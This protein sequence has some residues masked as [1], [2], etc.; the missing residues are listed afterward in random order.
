MMPAT[1]STSRVSARFDVIQQAD[2]PTRFVLVEVYRSEEDTVKHRQTAHFAAGAIRSMGCWLPRAHVS[3]TKMSIPMTR[4]GDNAAG[5]RF[6]HSSIKAVVLTPGGEIAASANRE[7]DSLYP[8]P[9]WVEQS[10]YAW[11]DKVV[12][13]IR[14][15][16]QEKPALAAQVSAVGFSGQMH[17]AVLLDAN[18]QPLRPA[19]IWADGRSQP[20]VDRVLE[21]FGP[22]YS[23]LTGNPLFTGF[24]LPTILWVRENEPEIWKRCRKVLLPKDYLRFLFTGQFLSEASDAS[25]TGMF[26]IARRVW[27]DCI[28]DGLDLEPGLLPDLIASTDIAGT[29]LP[30][31]ADQLGLPPGIPVICGGSDQACQAL[32][33]GIIN[34]GEVSCTIGTGGQVFAPLGSPL[35]DPYQ[36]LH[37]FCHILPDLWHIEA[38]TLSA[39]LSLRWLR[40]ILG[41]LS[42]AEMADLADQAPV[43]CDGLLFAPYLQGERTP[44]MDAQL[45]GGIVGLSIHH[46][47]QDLVRA[48][49]EGVV[50]SLRTGMELMT[51]ENPSPI[52]CGRIRRRR[53]ASTM[54]QADGRHLQYSGCDSWLSRSRFGRGSHAGGHWYRCVFKP[55]RGSPACGQIL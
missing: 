39:G 41:G 7:Y 49:M 25:S 5:D 2:D 6:G 46:T 9:G 35:A 8:K 45:R 51:G 28:L 27:S 43:G 33:N 47:R 1:A 40:G 23:R 14:Q 17:G 48:V 29:L 12:Q 10:P 38:A 44:Y 31:M 37:L 53:Q 50:L 55:S 19:V 30:E 42:Y 52:A 32:G 3:S 20:Q 26:D 24:M 36:R 4:T 22:E 34:P 54:A 21:Q 15:L 18:A 13:V 11:R 16:W